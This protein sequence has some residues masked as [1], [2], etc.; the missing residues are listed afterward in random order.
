MTDETRQRGPGPPV[1]GEDDGLEEQF[2][3]MSAQLAESYAALGKSEERFSLA[4]QGAND[5]LWDWDVRTNEVYYSPRWKGMLG[6]AEDEVEPAFSAWERLVH[7]D[8]KPAAMKKVEDFLSG[9][10]DKLEVEFRM[11]HKDGHYLDILSR[12]FGVREVPGGPIVR[13]VGTHINI[14]ERKR[15]EEEIRRQNEYLAALHETTLGLVSRLDVE[16]LLEALV[17]RAVSLV[18]ASFGFVDLV[19]PEEDKIEVTVGTGWYRE[20]VGLRAKRGEALSGKVWQSGRPM[21]VEDYRTWPG[22]IVHPES[23]LVGPL[24]GAPLMSGAEVIGVIGVARPPS[25]PPFGQDEVDLISRFAHLASITLDNARLHS[26]L[27]EELAERVRTEQALQNRLAFEK[28]IT[29]ISTEFINLAPD[30]IDAGIQRALRTIGEFTGSDRSYVFTFSPDG[31]TMDNTHEW[32][33]AGVEPLQPLYQVQPVDTLPWFMSRI[34][35]LET[36]HVPS[37]ADLPPE[38]DVDRER[39]LS[40]E[41][42]TRSVLNVPMVYLNQAVGLLGFDSVLA[43]KTWDQDSIAL[44]RIVG[45]V[46]VNALQHKRTQEALQAAYQTLDQ[47]VRERTHELATLNAVA[48]VVSRSLDLEEILSDALDQTMNTLNMEFGVAYRLAGDLEGPEEQLYLQP[49]VHRGLSEPFVLAARPLPLRGS[50]VGAAADRGQPVVWDVE[51]C[52]DGPERERLLWAEGGR[53]GVSIPLLAKGRLAGAMQL[54]TGRQRT[55]A[56]EQISL[57]AAVGQQVGVAVENARLYEA[58]RERYQEAERRRRVAEGMRETLSAIN[59]RKSLPEILDFIVRQACR[60]MGCDAT[61]IER[62]EGKERSLRFQSACG[63]DPELVSSMV[64]PLGFSISGQAVR[65]QRPIAVVDTVGQTARATREHDWPLEP[66]RTLL[67]RHVEQFPSLLSV[68]LVVRDD[69]YGALTFYYREPCRFSEEEVELAQSVADQAALA[70]ESA[71]LRE[72]AEQAAALA[73]R[74]RLARELHDSVTQS[75]YSVTMYTE[76]AARLLTSEQQAT[77]AE[78]LRD[79]RDTAQEALREMRLLIF[80]LRP[81]ALEQSGLAG[82][83]Q[84]RLDA[85]EKRGGVQAELRVEGVEGM[86]DAEWLPLAVQQELY[87]VAREALNNSLKH[88]KAQHLQVC[89]QLKGAVVRLEISDDGVGFD[90]TTAGERGGL[91]LRGMRERVQRISGQ[92]QIESAPDHGTRLTVEVPREAEGDK[93]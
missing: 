60:L 74:S 13:L 9:E 40:H 25:A 35:A 28:I 32:C 26:S 2:H 38:A 91:G 17:E 11:R 20:N 43:D 50:K 3:R 77:A 30:Q 39:C 78:C 58:E 48:A 6:Y 70:I 87:H 10:L 27:Q 12:A 55:F 90:P 7:A 31:T 79:A 61:A 85:V 82:A 29:D 83:L 21:A 14:T 49:L 8:D 65:E 84:A 54:L 52:P 88:A 42:P 69:V 68:P 4:M 33:R 51:E 62:L 81:L 67:Q 46:F 66:Q 80:E 23:D 63:L 41:P 92:L 75:L 64:F 37:V 72:Q 16:E 34:Q 47:R 15:A 18:D 56:P 5:G 45:E 86:A 89:L 73:E 76:A 24:M 57:M 44:L 22:R 19:R 53:Q 36:V 59:S 1:R 71:R 93:T